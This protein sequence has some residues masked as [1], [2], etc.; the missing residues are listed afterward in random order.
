MNRLLHAVRACTGALA[1]SMA[2]PSSASVV[3]NATRY[4]Y[5]ADAKEISIKVS[6]TGK[7]PV[8]S[9]AWIDD[10]DAS[11][12]PD[13][14]NVPFNLTPP[15]SR[16]ETG[17]AQTY[18]LAFTEGE[19]PQDI[20]SLFWVNILEVPPKAREE[21][22]SAMQLAF[23][24]RLKLFY[25]PV[26]LQGSPEKAAESL[27]WS[28]DEKGALMVRNESAFHVAVNEI[29]AAAG[30]EEVELEPFSIG[31]RSSIAVPL[32]DA[33]VRDGAATIRYRTI[34]DYGGFVEH[35]GKTTP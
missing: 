28:R 31:P 27:A 13:A 20:E 29:K 35:H 34:N 8:L 2:M 16:I 30:G 17:K 23:R 26:G 3:M 18:R 6:N 7:T 10:G 11:A 19:L 1:L 22:T 14:V 32:G 5:P 9:Q 33:T 25:R 24:Y 15:I 21:K 12:T 4:V